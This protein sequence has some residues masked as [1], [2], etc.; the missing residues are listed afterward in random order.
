MNKQMRIGRWFAL[1][2]EK[3]RGN[4]TYKSFNAGGIPNSHIEDNIELQGKGR[5]FECCY[6]LTIWHYA[7]MPIK[8]EGY[9][10]LG[11]VS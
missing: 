1:R 2:R 9:I 4:V 5:C 10:I 7:Q 6:W 8:N 11:D 3:N